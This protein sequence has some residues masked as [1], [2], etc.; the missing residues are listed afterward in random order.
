MSRMNDWMRACNEESCRRL[1]REAQRRQRLDA[2]Q[3]ARRMRDAYRA[4][5]VDRRQR[6]LFRDLRL[7]WGGGR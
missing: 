4:N 3:L 1:L 2:F 6:A 5:D 7:D